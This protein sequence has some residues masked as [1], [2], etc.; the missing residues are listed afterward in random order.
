[1]VTVSVI[2]GGQCPTNEIR[3]VTNSLVHVENKHV[4][5]STKNS[6]E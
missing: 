2:Q 6:Q 4:T 5:P 3:G 1:M